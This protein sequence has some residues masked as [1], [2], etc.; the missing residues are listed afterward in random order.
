MEISDKVSLTSYANLIQ[1]VVFGDDD[2]IVA[3][4]ST[5]DA[6]KLAALLQHHATRIMLEE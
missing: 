3:N 1:I 6:L 5:E 4:L 2:G